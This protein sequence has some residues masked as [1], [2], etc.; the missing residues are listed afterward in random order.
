MSSRSTSYR[1]RRSNIR[2]A[3][4]EQL[5]VAKP[6]SR[7]ELSALVDFSNAQQFDALSEA[8]VL[9]FYTET[10]DAVVLDPDGDAAL[11][12]IH[13]APFEFDNARSLGTYES[14]ASR[15]QYE[16]KPHPNQVLV[17]RQV[18]LDLGADAED[19][20]VLVY[21]R[22][23]ARASPVRQRNQTPFR[24]AIQEQTT[25]VLFRQFSH[26]PFAQATLVWHREPRI[27]STVGL[28]AVRIETLYE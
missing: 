19:I 1:R 4:S 7:E 24:T 14:L 12:Q 6:P 3:G 27:N 21:K 22:D 11:L 28:I 2:R 5:V 17:K 9:L 23:T 10:S 25:I 16:C 26:D 20:V 15:A 13:E 18:V 8:A